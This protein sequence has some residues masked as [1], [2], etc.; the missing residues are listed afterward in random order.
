MIVRRLLADVG[1]RNGI[2]KLRVRSILS[3][4]LSAIVRSRGRRPA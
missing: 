2:T 4:I 1:A 3:A